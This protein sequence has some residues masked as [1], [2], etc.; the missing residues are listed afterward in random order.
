MFSGIVETQARVLN[1][2]MGHAAPGSPAA[3]WAT[4]SN[5]DS[6]VGPASGHDESG[7]L[8]IDV[9]RPRD[10]NDIKIGDSICHNGVCL[11]VESFDAQKMTFALGAETLKVTHWTVAALSGAMLNLERSLGFGDRIHG[12]M[13]SGHVDDVGTV[14]LVKDLG[15]TVQV[16]VR[17]PKALLPSIW[18][19]GGWAMN[20]VS[21]T[22]NDVQGDIV[23]V[24]L[25]PET[26]RRT[27]LGAIK[28]GDP[29]NIEVDMLARG[30]RNGIAEF[31][32][33]GIESG[34]LN[35]LILELT[36]ARSST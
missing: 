10:F 1:A 14:V 4:Q 13:V 6:N 5:S 24:C 35:E 32:K 22:V 3:Q 33:S 11:T 28:A 7:L 34:S 26:L 29:V 15:G 19:K 8:F 36:G 16:D 31:L 18:K 27:N 23:S 20:G 17:A 2:R 25:V 12:H 9:E 21:L 30:I